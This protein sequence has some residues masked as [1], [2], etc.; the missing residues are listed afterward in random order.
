MPSYQNGPL[1]FFPA[2]TTFT[3]GYTQRMATPI[4]GTSYSA[5]KVL[6]TYQSVV[7]LV[8]VNGFYLHDYTDTNPRSDMQKNQPFQLYKIYATTLSSPDG[9]LPFKHGDYFIPN[10][11][12]VGLVSGTTHPI[13]GILP[14][15][16]YYQ[17]LIIE[18][19]L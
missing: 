17:E 12:C 2:F 9:D 16:G 19:K 6:T 5:Q 7:T 8:M 18:R 10:A 1:A 14:N 15:P 3:A 13:R 11:N 4:G